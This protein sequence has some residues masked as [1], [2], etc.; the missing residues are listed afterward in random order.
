V[1]TA[2]ARA[3]AAGGDF[4]DVIDSG[5]AVFCIYLAQG[6]QKAQSEYNHFIL[7]TSRFLLQDD[8]GHDYRHHHPP[9]TL[10]DG[11][12]DRLQSK[13][14]DAEFINQGAITKHPKPVILLILHFGSGQP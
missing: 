7:P 2:T 13:N 3:F 4:D 9:T 10:G 11:G 14:K 1:N 5:N 6:T 8:Y 12:V